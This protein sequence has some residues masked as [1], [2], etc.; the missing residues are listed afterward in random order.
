MRF[1][2]RQKGSGIRNL[3]D[4]LIKQEKIDPASLKGYDHEVYT[5]LDV[6][7]MVATENSDVGLSAESAV[8]SSR[9][10]FTPIFEERF[11]MIVKKEAFFDQHVQAFVEFI[12]SDLFKGILK[13]LKG[14]SYR[15]T[16]KVVYPK[17]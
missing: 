15:E 3:V 7:R 10:V 9:L 12:R 11:D 17:S 6:A 5:H 8:V 14:Y 2:N 4:H 16:G 1:V 13:T